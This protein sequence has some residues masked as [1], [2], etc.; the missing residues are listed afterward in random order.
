MIRGRLARLVPISKSRGLRIHSAPP[1]ANELFIRNDF[2]RAIALKYPDCRK[3]IPELEPKGALGISV[4]QEL[5]RIREGADAEGLRPLAS[6]EHYLRDLIQSC[7]NGWH[8]QTKRV[9]NYAALLNQIRRHTAA[10][11]VTFDYDTLFETSLYEFGFHR[12]GLP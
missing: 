2:F 12:A 8:D 6:M 9:S 7:Q 4:E 10:C 11:F 1:L 3:L 5:Q